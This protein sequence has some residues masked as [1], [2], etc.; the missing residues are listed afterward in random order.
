M[1]MTVGFRAY[2]QEQSFPVYRAERIRLD[3][4]LGSVV[5]VQVA[6]RNDA[7]TP[8]LDEVWVATSTGQII[9]QRLNEKF[10]LDRQ[11][12]LPLIF[13]LHYSLFLESTG[14]TLLGILSIIWVVSLL[15]GLRLAWPKRNYLKVIQI[16]LSASKVRVIF[17]IHR[18]IGAICIPILLLIC[19]TGIYLTLTGWVLPIIQSVAATTPWPPEFPSSPENDAVPRLPETSIKIAR[20]L[21]PDGTPIRLVINPSHAFHRIDLLRSSDAGE[22]PETVVFVDMYDGKV[23]TKI[24]A[25]KFTPGD[26]FISWQYPLHTGEF[27]RTPGRILWLIVGL[28]PLI[29]FIT[30]VLLFLRKKIPSL[31]KT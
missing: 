19:L 22:T 8:E 17:D 10:K 29:F 28:S 2:T 23:L 3:Y 30:G 5:L 24:S 20:K 7:F 26:T 6:P 31:V 21:F 4:Q 1:R 25:E 11:H 9:S 15:A 16:K 27:L 12:L 13:R 14:Q 18:A